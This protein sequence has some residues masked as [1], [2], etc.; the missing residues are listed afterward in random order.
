MLHC[1]FQGRIKSLANYNSLTDKHL[2][3]YFSNTRIRRHL[4]R[5]GLISR[6]G[7]IIPEKE[8]QLNTMKKDH[9]KYIRECL[10]QAIFHKVLDM[11]RHHQVEIKRKLENSARRE[12]VQRIKVERSRKAT[13]ETYH[14][15]SPHPSTAPRNRFG[16]RKLGNRGQS[17]H[18]A[19]CPRPNTAPGN[20]QHPVRL[21]PLFGNIT[22]ESASKATLSSRTK[23][24]T[25]EKEHQF[26]C[27]GDRGAPKPML[28][29]D[30]SSGVSPYRFPIINNYVIP[31]PPPP[32]SEK[33]ISTGKGVT[34]RGRRLRPTTAP[35]GLEQ[36]LIRDSGRFYRPQ[37][38][39]NA[40]VTMIYLG[41]T[42][43]L[44]YDLLDYREE[45]KVYQQHCGG[46][47]LCVFRGKLLEGETFQ[48]VSRR[49][50][51]FPFSLTFYLNGIQV[52]RL[53]SCCEYKHRR[54]TRL[55]GKHGHFGFV[56]V[57][58][59][60]PCY[61]CI[62]AMGLDKKP[63]PPKKKVFDEDE[64]KKEDSEKDKGKE[65]L[66]EC[67][68][69]KKDNKNLQ[70]RFSSAAEEEKEHVEGTEEMEWES[71]RGDTH[72][73][74][75]GS[76]K[77][78]RSGAYDEDFEADEE[79]SD[80]KVN[81]EG[82]ADDQ[83]NGMSKS[84][85]DD[86]K[87][88]LDHERK[89]KNSSQKALRASDSEQ[90]ESDG[91]VESD[92][93]GE[94]KQDKNLA[95]SLSSSSTPYLSEN[96]SDSETR[97]QDGEQ[98]NTDIH[99]E[100]ESETKS[101]RGDSQETE[102]E[103][104][105]DNNRTEY[106]TAK[107]TPDVSYGRKME[108]NLQDMSSLSEKLSLVGSLDVDV[109]EEEI[110]E[111]VLVHFRGSIPAAESRSKMTSEDE[112]EGESKSAKEKIAEAIEHDQLLSS[113]PEPSDSSTEDEEEDAVGTGDKQEVTDGASLAKKSRGPKSQTVVEQVEQERQ[114]VGKERTLEEVEIL[115]Q[116]GP[117][118]TALEDESLDKNVV[119][120]AAQNAGKDQLVREETDLE[121]EAE[122][123]SDEDYVEE[124][125]MHEKLKSSE[126]ELKAEGKVK[127]PKEMLSEHEISEGE[128]LSGG[129]L[130]EEEEVEDQSVSGDLIAVEEASDSQEGGQE[131]PEA[132]EMLGT[133]ESVGKK[134]IEN[135]VQETKETIQ[136]AF[137]GDE[138][139]E[140][141][142]VEDKE[143]NMEETK[144]E[145]NGT[146]PDHKPGTE[147]V[148]K[149]E[150]TDSEG[151][152]A[153][154]LKEEEHMKEREDTEINLGEASTIEAELIEPDTKV[155]ERIPID[156][157]DV[158][159]E[160][161]VD[162]DDFIRE[163]PFD[164]EA[165]IQE[166]SC[167]LEG[168]S[169]KITPKMSKM[170]TT[171]TE[172]VSAVEAVEEE[173]KQEGRVEMLMSGMT[174]PKRKQSIEKEYFADVVPEALPFAT[175]ESIRQAEEKRKEMVKGEAD[176][177]E[178]ERKV[179]V[180]DKVKAEETK[181]KLAIEGDE[182]DEETQRLLTVKWKMKDEDSESEGEILSLGTESEGEPTS[183][184]TIMRWQNIVN[185]EE[186]TV[187]EAKDVPESS[188]QKVRLVGGLNKESGME[189]EPDVQDKPG[190]TS[191]GTGQTSVYMK[192]QDEE[193][194]EDEGSD[195]EEQIT[196]EGI[197]L[198]DVEEALLIG[199]QQF[200]TEVSRLNEEVED[201]EEDS[202]VEDLAE[203]EI[204]NQKD[205]DRQ[206]FF[207]AGMAEERW[208][209]ESKKVD[210]RGIGEPVDRN[211]L[212]GNDGSGKKKT[213]QEESP[214]ENRAVTEVN[215]WSTD[216]SEGGQP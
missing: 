35:N 76:D 24:L 97:R 120:L 172:D 34:S 210:E 54:G 187:A 160:K 15:L 215:Q 90:D 33:N 86:E 135:E 94:D 26:P 37:V 62:I 73:T 162:E 185:L 4:L 49:H 57:E 153:T 216:Q 70:S 143:K 78:Q 114:M 79:K 168:Y 203:E 177:E 55:G 213:R 19:T 53:S 69:S 195:T 64:A 214:E 132:S 134:G 191:E 146:W 212:E 93:E 100:Y 27:A 91:Y 95:P 207:S 204:S 58:R 65:G 82:Q 201:K 68:S 150:L 147:G 144:P 151:V 17:V 14:Q 129:Y 56:N 122:V 173:T 25:F 2:A 51:G 155:K 103:E 170:E 125:E 176:A 1:Q 28:S 179:M 138:A 39:S 16:R 5:S 157:K 141:A 8:Y 211:S 200:I 61:R 3:G 74:S 156:E 105:G 131:V 111:D 92:S 178:A 121:K 208:Q 107:R 43:H 11:E 6:S 106:T 12:R 85:S 47:N 154:F 99:S 42:V 112:E 202:P 84:P 126:G 46:E 164:L 189:N 110:E 139:L 38:Q 83:M 148:V 30:Y 29:I 87:D 63:S 115:E 199:I 89:N 193:V 174:A 32:K 140:T 128:E 71:R 158:A 123:E 152:S 36:L 7:R 137:Q 10:A 9:Q 209:A 40:C 190:E 188:A 136:E 101:Q 77:D 161:L 48:F 50:Y 60:A 44:S 109:R 72:E 98:D 80:E 192:V 66:G 116:G 124:E 96:V 23:F 181:R 198:A 142:S 88:N 18:S 22:T 119:A 205:L 81:E 75:N 41:K 130:L 59:S 20:I 196:G 149:E 194:T 183:E 182:E 166:D 206:D 127:E 21:Q 184:M 52:D 145:R 180:K 108:A 186:D 113:E 169:E 175:E 165:S 133:V 31:I 163:A 118:D 104:E 13:E 45:V 197:T 102:M 171:S 159:L 67:S 117:K 167:M